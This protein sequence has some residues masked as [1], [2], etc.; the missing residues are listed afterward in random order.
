[1]RREG[2]SYG[3]IEQA[4]LKQRHSAGTKGEALLR[5]INTQRGTGLIR[6]W[7]RKPDSQL[8][9]IPL[10]LTTVVTIADYVWPGVVALVLLYT[11][12]C[13]LKLQNLCQ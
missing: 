13:P 6:T 3:L 4:I 8:L 12:K 11:T 2:I 1:M 9:Q 5:Q 7:S 10:K